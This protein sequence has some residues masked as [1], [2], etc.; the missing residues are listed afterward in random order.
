[1][2]IFRIAYPYWDVSTKT[3]KYKE[4][5]L[6]PYSDI[7]GMALVDWDADIS[8]YRE[9]GLFQ[10]SPL[11]PGREWVYGVLTNTTE[12][13]RLSIVGYDEDDI[14]LALDE[15]FDA[16]QASQTPWLDREQPIPYSYLKIQTKQEGNPRYAYIVQARLSSLGKILQQ[17]FY[18]IKQSQLEDLTL[19]V[20]HGPWRANIP[21]SGECVDQ[22]S[23]S[24]FAPV[25]LI[26]GPITAYGQYVYDLFQDKKFDN[27]IEIGFS[28]SGHSTNEG[29]SFTSDSYGGGTPGDSHRGCE[30]PGLT[31]Y[32]V[33]DSSVGGIRRSSDSGVIW[34]TVPYVLP[35]NTA[36]SYTV[37]FGKYS[38]RLYLGYR[39][40]VAFPYG[41]TISYSTDV[42]DSWTDI[43][44]SGIYV[45]YNTDILEPELNT[46]LLAYDYGIIG[47]FDD[48]STWRVVFTVPSG[49]TEK[50]I[51][52]LRQLDDG[53][54]VACGGGGVAVSSDNGLSWVYYR[55]N[56]ISGTAVAV[57]DL[58]LD[59]AEYGN[60]F[61]YGSSNFSSYYSLRDDFENL[62]EISFTWTS[63]TPLAGA[64]VSGISCVMATNDGTILFGI[65]NN[66]ADDEVQRYV[67]GSQLDY[68]ETQCGPTHVVN[69]RVLQNLTH[70]KYYDASLAAYTDILPAGSFPI[71]LFPDPP[72]ASDILYFLIEAA[73]NNAGPV[74]HIAFNISQPAVDI[75][76]IVWEV[77]SAGAWN[78]VTVTDGTNGFTAIGPVVVTINTTA[79]A[80]N[81]VVD[82]VT[83]YG[84]RARITAV[85]S[86]PSAPYQDDW[87]VFALS[88]PYVDISSIDGD[89]SA[90]TLSRFKNVAYLSGTNNYYVNRVVCGLRRVS[91][92]ENFS[93]FLN[94][95]DQRV[96]DGLVVSVGTDCAFQAKAG[97]P[98]ERSILYNPTTTNTNADRAIFSLNRILG[99]EYTGTY[100]AYVRVDSDTV[101]VFTVRLR[102][103]RGAGGLTYYTDAVQVPNASAYVVLDMGDI[104]IPRQKY[105]TDVIQIAVQMETTD[106]AANIEIIDLILIPVDEWAGD[107]SDNANVSDSLIDIDEYLEIDGLTPKDLP[108]LVLT[109]T[110]LVKSEYVPS[111]NPM[112]LEPIGDDTHRLWIFT[113]RTSTTGTD[114][115][116]IAEPQMAQRVEIEKNE[117]YLGFKRT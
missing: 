98:G 50:R 95:S 104:N 82:G 38:R 78:A 33:A 106:A 10:S 3:Y 113:M 49:I 112:V 12:N 58:I 91:R 93:A 22:S 94:A 60:Y 31:G 107:Y 75:T 43:V 24:E 63:T 69:K 20:E 5:D 59:I 15:F 52:R 4:L 16:W 89:I 114:Y 40:S 28:A 30:V 67:V 41:F 34:T 99:L 8:Q 72:A 39:N 57:S 9:G 18:T 109:S 83:G 85:G 54:V 102:V 25:E 6:L 92:G 61:Y 105:S 26:D 7:S 17:P 51:Y 68:G 19:T 101:D 84:I 80:S 55:S 45:E 117:G 62:Y 23:V 77:W 73:V 11:Y 42:G 35:A 1:M 74:Y 70:V 97:A 87:D 88:V 13:I 46:I 21:G 100:H 81:A 32:I 103:T 56:V 86:N 44:D 111:G 110:D 53:R 115:V 79:F 47:S 96:P 108:V 48:G 36:E 76:T 64:I 14:I 37:H 27:I 66:A 29:A 116:W 2:N 65:I 90:I 71:E